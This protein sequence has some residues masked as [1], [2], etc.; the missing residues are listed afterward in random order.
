[1]K[2]LILAFIVLSSLNARALESK[3]VACE[4]F[5]VALNNVH[6]MKR[7]NQGDIKIFEVDMIEPAAAPVGVA[8]TI[9]RGDE[10]SSMESFC[11]YVPG[12]VDVDLASLQV[13][14]DEENYSLVLNVRQ[15]NANDEVSAKKLTLAVNKKANSTAELVKAN[16]E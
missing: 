3:V 6:D 4:D 13:T 14:Q 1:M 2:N 11:R 15:T 10:F 16:L 9:S 12:L 5:G 7:L 8:I